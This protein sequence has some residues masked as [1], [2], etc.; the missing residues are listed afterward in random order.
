MDNSKPQNLRIDN[1]DKIESF[2]EK[3]K[4]SKLKKKKSNIKGQGNLPFSIMK[5]DNIC[6]CV[7]I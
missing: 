3:H 4:L 2:L 7:Y 6:I 1:W 5:A